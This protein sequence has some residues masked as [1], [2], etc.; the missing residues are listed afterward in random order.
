MKRTMRRLNIAEHIPIHALFELY[1]KPKKI[2]RAGGKIKRWSHKLSELG[3]TCAFFY[4]LHPKQ[5]LISGSNSF[6]HAILIYPDFR[7]EF[8][9]RE[10]YITSNRWEW[11]NKLGEEYYDKQIKTKPTTFDNIFVPPDIQELITREIENRLNQFPTLEKFNLPTKRGIIFYGEP[12]TGKTSICLA[13]CAKYQKKI[14]YARI[15]PQI[16]LSGG[17]SFKTRFTELRNKKKPVIL[18]LED[19]DIYLRDRVEGK[20]GPGNSL[21]GQLLEEMDGFN[22]NQRMFVILSTNHPSLLDD[23][24]LRP[25]RFDV[26]IRIEAV[27]CHKILLKMLEAQF[28][29]IR[30]NEDIV[31]EELKKLLPMTPAVAV[32]YIQI[33]AMLTIEQQGE[34]EGDILTIPDDLL[35][36]AFATHEMPK[37]TIFE[38]ETQKVGF[39]S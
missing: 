30:Y 9:N 38:K 8:S 24:I 28:S 1:G 21:L 11:A 18:F 32:N 29:Q 17:F 4:F 39:G 34:I 19:A 22:E 2:V 36:E 23:A 37:E 15:T 7:I 27:K 5:V 3:G 35:R 13:I 6:I 14:H 31:A 25:G 12:G 20:A 33:A 26:A 16:A 10:T